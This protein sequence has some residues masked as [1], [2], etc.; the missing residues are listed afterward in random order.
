MSQKID[1]NKTVYNKE[2][3]K[4]TI[5]T[6]FSQL[7]IQTIQEQIDSEITINQFF[8]IYNDLFFDIPERGDI[9]SHEFLIKQSSEYINFNET[10][11]EIEAL[12]NE[13]AQLRQ[14]LL[15]SQQQ[16]I[17]LSSNQNS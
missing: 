15:D 8:E 2:L 10:N 14:Q 7:G 16:I 11:S 9:N 4:K 13:I 12:Q 1:L 5:N 17:N 6:E 3:Y